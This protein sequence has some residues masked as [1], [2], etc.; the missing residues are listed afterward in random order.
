M[1]P[2]IPRQMGSSSSNWPHYL[3]NAAL[4]LGLVEMGLPKGKVL[5]G[6]EM[7]SLGGKQYLKRESRSPRYKCQVG[8]EWGG[9]G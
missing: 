6:R 5:D 8:R 1:E 9:E 7:K 3:K 2:S 4:S